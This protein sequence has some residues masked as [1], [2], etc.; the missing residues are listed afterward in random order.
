M[1][2]ASGSLRCLPWPRVKS[3]CA[4]PPWLWHVFWS[5]A[6][7][8]KNKRELQLAR[9]LRL[10]GARRPPWLAR[11]AIS[12]GHWL[13]R[14]EKPQ[15]DWL[16]RLWKGMSSIFSSISMKTLTR[17]VSK[18]ILLIFTCRTF[19]WQLLNYLFHLRRNL[20]YI[21]LKLNFVRISFLCIQFW[22]YC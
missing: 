8:I 7:I 3:W 20:Y 21:Y 2:T 13:V 17:T 6:R 15:S 1:A 4:P 22:I 9:V 14:R 10:S 12:L 19:L 16:S 18:P 11:W 5:A